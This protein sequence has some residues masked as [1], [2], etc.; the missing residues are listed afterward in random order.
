M[1]IK[2][3]VKVTVI[4]IVITLVSCMLVSCDPV[5]EQREDSG[6]LFWEVKS[7]DGKRMFLL[8][9]IHVADDDIYPFSDVVMYAFNESSALAVEVDIDALN[10]DVQLQIQVLQY[11]M[12]DDGSTIEDHIDEELFNR[13]KQ[14]LVDRDK[15][16]ES[17]LLLKPIFWAE[18]LS[19]VA[20]EKTGLSFDKGVDLYFLK[21][22]KKAKK[23]ILQVESATGQA[24]ALAGLSDAMQEFY[25]EDTLNNVGNLV[26]NTLDLYEIWKEADVDKLEK[27]V[28]NVDKKKT[29]SDEQL[30][31]L[32]EFEKVMIIDR[33][34]LMVEKAVEYINSGKTVFFV[35]GAAHMIGESGLVNQLESKGYE[36]VKR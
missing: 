4:F 12:Y 23:E 10:K 28:Y 16:S 7:D 15:Y 20:A 29:L 17:Y 21:E 3:F 18:L 36:V 26:R 9:S 19:E 31:A 24:E 22:A 14:Y 6:V 27:Y 30:E 33:N 25:L 13:A 34:K 35:V 32:N 1:N 5:D 11:F 2:G 8:G